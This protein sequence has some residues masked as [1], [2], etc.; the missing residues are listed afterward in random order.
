MSEI[1]LAKRSKFVL[2]HEHRPLFISTLFRSIDGLSDA[3]KKAW[4]NFWKKIIDAGEGEVFSVEVKKMRNGKFFRKWWALVNLAYEAWSDGLPA[5][6]INGTRVLPNF[7]EFRKDVTIKAGF[8]ES[9]FSLNGDLKLSAKSISWA[10]MNEQTFEE[11]YQATITAILRF[12][13][14]GRRLTPESL[15][16]WVEKVMGMA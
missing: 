9:V 15:N 1:T 11:L 16:A 5:V 10:A 13:L 14:P 4:R 12:V 3:D 2:S 7:D 6:D 8:Y